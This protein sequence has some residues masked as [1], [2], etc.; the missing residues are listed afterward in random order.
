MPTIRLARARCSGAAVIALL[1]MLGC[2]SGGASAANGS[3]SAIGNEGGFV[4]LDGHDV[5]YSA[6]NDSTGSTVNG[7]AVIHASAQFRSLPAPHSEPRQWRTHGMPRII[8]GATVGPLW[9]GFEQS[10]NSAWLD[11]I[12]V[13]LDTN[14][15]LFVEI[16]EQRRSRVVGQARIETRLPVTP[17]GC[18][19]ISHEQRHF[20]FAE[21]L[22]G[23]LRAMPQVR[24]FLS[25]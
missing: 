16:D 10:T 21:A 23:R 18:D 9:I 5:V 20:L 2:R 24:A 15:V 6:T 22:S 8:G 25:R 1:T 7:V 13:P 12:A 19:A 17:N 3:C 4:T 11:S 14:N